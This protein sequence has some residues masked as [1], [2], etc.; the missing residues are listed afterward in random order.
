M[1]LVPKVCAL[2]A[3]EGAPV[4]FLGGNPGVAEQAAAN[5]R[6]AYPGLQVAGAYG[7]PFGFE[8][9]PEEDR[10]AV[11]RVKGSGA[12][13]LFVALGSPK[14]EKWAAQHMTELGIKLAL[15]IGSALDYPAGMARRAPRWMQDGGLEWLWRLT[16]EPGRLAKRYFID[17]LPFFTLVLKEWLR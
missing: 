5:L 9:D 17:D 13:V 12:A 11:E 16:L 8:K 3:E 2:A 4:F 1:D 10:K 14:Q 6:K 7:P 15:C